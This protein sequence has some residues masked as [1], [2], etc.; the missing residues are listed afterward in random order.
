[1][2][3]RLSEEQLKKLI[4]EDLGVSRAALA[5]TNL[6]YSK[7]EPEVKEFLTNKKNVSKDIRITTEEMSYVYQSSMDDFI[8]LPMNSIDIKLKLNNYPNRSTKIPFTTGGLAYQIKKKH[9]GYSYLEEPSFE[10]PKYILEEI[11]QAMV[12]KVEFNVSLYEDYEDNM[13]ESVLLDLRDTITHETNHV[14]ESYRRASSGSKQ[15]N[16]ALVYSGIKNY[17]VKKEIF[18]F[19]SVFT[20]YL[21]KSEPYEV[22]AK[23]Q[24]AFSLRTR[25]PFEEFKKTKYWQEAVLLKEFEA[26]V[27]VDELL[28]K[29]IELSPERA[30]SIVNNLYKWFMKE[31]YNEMRLYGQKPAKLIES[32]KGLSDLVKRL[33]PRINKAGETLLK[34][35]M[36]LYALEPEI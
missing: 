9:S 27:Y 29:I 32:S 10:L 13:S 23:V 33:Q 35:Y 20:N 1:M 25:M 28:E 14:Y 19:W 22:N 15:I 7:L 12:A 36:R 24:E 17:N 16:T 26:E 30:K 6:I 18:D 4:K 31:Y 8:E 3:V 34:K 21:Y 5:Y 11:D 2:R